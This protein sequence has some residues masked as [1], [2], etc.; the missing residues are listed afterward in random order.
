MQFLPQVGTHGGGGGGGKGREL[1]QWSPK[2]ISRHGLGGDYDHIKVYSFT[3]I[4]IKCTPV[5]KATSIC[6]AYVG[7]NT[8][9]L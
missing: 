1:N 7:E 3:F 8:R 4:H 9:K 6:F 5:L 2:Q